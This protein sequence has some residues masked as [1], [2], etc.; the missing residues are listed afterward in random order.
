[1]EQAPQPGEDVE[2]VHADFG[3][4]FAGAVQISPAI[5]AGDAGNPAG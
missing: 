2:V 4:G 5:A 1:M 3:S